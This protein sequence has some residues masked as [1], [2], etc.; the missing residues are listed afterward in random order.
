MGRVYL[1][2]DITN[3]CVLFAVKIL[4]L[5][6]ANTQL[7]ESFGREIFIGAQLGRKKEFTYYLCIDLW[8]F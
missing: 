2:E 1:A 3:N 5:S 8:Y 7:A 4:S 6:I